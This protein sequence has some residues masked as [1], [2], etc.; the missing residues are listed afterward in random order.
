MIEFIP[1]MLI[2]VLWRPDE[3]GVFDIQRESHLFVSEEAC[4]SAGENRV[5]GVDMDHREHSGAKVSY[6]CMTVPDSAEYA[7]L[8]AEFD[9]QNRQDKTNMQMTPDSATGEGQ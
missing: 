7:V 6:T 2:L 4:R 9:E 3:P 5:A 8:F 1:W